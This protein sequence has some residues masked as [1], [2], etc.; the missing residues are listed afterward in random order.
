MEQGPCRYHTVCLSQGQTGGNHREGLEM[1]F[2]P[3]KALTYYQPLIPFSFPHRS[4]EGG[5]SLIMFW[6][7]KGSQ[8]TA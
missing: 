6:I 1:M 2:D 7:L 3:Q 4:A 8:E 5:T